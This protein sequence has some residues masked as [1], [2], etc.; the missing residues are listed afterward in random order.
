MHE[1]I[2]TSDDVDQAQDYFEHGASATVCANAIDDLR[3]TI[4]DGH[5]PDDERD[6]DAEL[7]GSQHGDDP[8][9]N[10]QHA[11]RYGPTGDTLYAAKNRF[12][13]SS[14]RTIVRVRPVIFNGLV[15]RPPARF[16]RTAS[17]PPRPFCL[18]S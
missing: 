16:C 6:D 5:P 1:E 3:D 9:D 8:Q 17:C 13:H 4:E 10:H 11:K 15:S 2:H 12:S 14:S 18:P 7:P